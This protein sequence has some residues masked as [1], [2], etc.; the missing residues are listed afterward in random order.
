[1]S[2]KPVY[3]A[4][5]GPVSIP[6]YF[7]KTRETYLAKWRDGDTYRQRRN[8]DLEALKASMRRKAKAMAAGFVE[9]SDLTPEQLATVSEVVRRGITLE[10]VRSIQ[11]VEPLSIE[12]AVELFLEDKVEISKPYWRTLKTNLGQVARRLKG[13]PIASITVGE[14]DEWLH[15]ATRNHRTRKNK[16]NCLVAFWRWCRDK[17]YLPPDTRTAAERTTPPSMTKEKRERVTPTWSPEEMVTI[18]ELIPD[19]YLPWVVF[20]AFAGLRTQELFLEEKDPAHRKAVLQWSDVHASGS[21]PRIVVP[22]AVSKTASKRS[23]PITPNLAQWI[24][25]IPNR[26]GAILKEQPPWRR[27][28]RWQNNSCIKLLSAAMATPWRKNALRHSFGT[29]RVIETQSLDQTALEMDNSS[30]IIKAHYLD[31][32][33]TRAEAAAY[34]AITPDQ[35]DRSKAMAV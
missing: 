19:C 18:L 4:R 3:V 20:S 14:L 16:R 31:I 28:Y 17:D 34:F 23:I 25:T 1:M 5:S 7:S 27:I 2:S 26:R 13:R 12:K 8:K 11:T 15:V 35:V 29:Y 33:R 32:G 24:L 22:S 6:I 30:S 10:Q 9:L 21:N